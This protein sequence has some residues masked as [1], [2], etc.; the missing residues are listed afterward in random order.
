[1]QFR[2]ILPLIAY[3]ATRAETSFPE[4]ENVVVLTEDNF[5]AFLASKPVSLVEFYVHV[6]RL[7]TTSHTLSEFNTSRTLS[8]FKADSPALQLT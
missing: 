2:W 7:N 5:D 1:M 6:L 8:E 4:E 3:C